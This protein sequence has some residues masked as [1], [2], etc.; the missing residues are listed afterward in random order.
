MIK[1]SEWLKERMAN[2]STTT[3]SVAGYAR[4]VGEMVTRKF[5]KPIIFKGKDNNEKG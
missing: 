4:R 2:E 1:F 3:A 5:T